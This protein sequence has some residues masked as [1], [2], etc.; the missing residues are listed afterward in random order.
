MEVVGAAGG[1]L[2]AVLC[3][4]IDIIF[5]SFKNGGN[6]C[7]WRITRSRVLLPS[8]CV[9]LT[10]KTHPPYCSIEDVGVRFFILARE[11]R[12]QFGEGD[13]GGNRRAMSLSFVNSATCR[14]AC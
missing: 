10:T 2:E 11:M 5:F 6:R 7:G 12:R 3:Y 14:V 4:T 13:G 8:K 9:F 1:S